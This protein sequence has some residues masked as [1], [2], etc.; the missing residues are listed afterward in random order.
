VPQSTILTSYPIILDQDD[1]LQRSINQS[2]PDLNRNIQ[3]H[4]EFDNLTDRERT[5]LRY[6]DAVERLQKSLK[7]RPAN[8]ETFQISSLPNIITNSN[9]D[10]LC[11]LQAEINKI[12][13][14][15]KNSVKNANIL[16]KGKS[17]VERTF[18]ALSPFAKNILIVAKEGQS[19]IFSSL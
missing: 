4:A 8:W 16:S 11:Y 17:I 13:E 6:K 1:S 7:H 15:H 5:E 9:T 18:K 12:L 2:S 14:S 3:E 19:V 10:H